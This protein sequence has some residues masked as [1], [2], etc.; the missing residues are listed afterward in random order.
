MLLLNQ[1][2]TRKLYIRFF[3]L[4]WDPQAQSPA[5]RA[6]IRFIRKPVGFSVIPVVFITNQTMLRCKIPDIPELAARLFR[7]ISQIS[8]Q[9]GIDP[10][11]IQL[12]C[13]WTAT[14]RDRYFQLLREIKN[15]YTGTVSATI[16]LHQIKYSE[17]TG[18][19]PVERGMLMFYNMADWKRPETRNSIYDLEVANRYIDF[20]EK[21]PLPLDVVF[22]LFRWTVVYRNNRFLTLLNS[23]DQQTLSR[24]SFLKP[25]PENRFV[26]QRD[27]NALGF[28]IRQGDVFR[29]ER[30]KPDDL[31][32]GKQLVLAK[33]QNQKLTFAL[34]HLDSTVISAYSD[35]FLQS[36][37]RSSP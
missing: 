10:Q 25:Q 9:N 16:R 26:A 36:L 11:E 32:L 28:S 20:M 37:F 4:D 22:P 2:K 8:H 5:P 1:L 13:D 7:K 29:A 31:A 34:Y 3:D 30:S 27:T 12:D 19:P 33:I 14:T 21:Y 23:M 6:V 35:A 24:H 15:R 17:Q 18:I